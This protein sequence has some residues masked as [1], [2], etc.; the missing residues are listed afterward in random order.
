MSQPRTTTGPN[1][2]PGASAD[3]YIVVVVD[4][5]AI[6]RGLLARAL[7]TDPEIKVVETVANGQ[8]AIAAVTRSAPD[9]VV[10]DIEMPVM[11]GL[12]ALPEIIK[13]DPTVKVIMASTLTLRNADISMRALALGAADYI[14]KPTSA[15]DISQGF[16]FKS[17]LIAKVKA[18]AAAGRRDRGH[19]PRRRLR[20]AGGGASGSRRR[21]PLPRRRNRRRQLCADLLSAR[22]SWNLAHHPR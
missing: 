2:S 6:I 12:T 8:L 14:P 5:S 1:P 17:E 16:D 22:S 9:V 13:A 20:R 18:L 15:G 19:R 4:D 7:E 10:L 21:G 3:P 11:D